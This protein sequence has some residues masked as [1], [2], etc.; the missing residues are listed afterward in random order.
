VHDDAGRVVALRTDRY[1]GRMWRRDGEG[2][3]WATVYRSPGGVS[4]R[5]TDLASADA[6]VMAVGARISPEGAVIKSVSVLLAPSVRRTEFDVTA[7]GEASLFAVTAWDG[8]WVAANTGTNGTDLWESV[9]GS[10]WTPSAT[11][12]HL[13]TLAVAA[14]DGSGGDLLAAGNSIVNG[15][16]TVVSTDSAVPRTGR[17]LQAP[18]GATPAIVVSMVANGPAPTIAYN[19]TTGTRI[20]H[21]NRG[22]L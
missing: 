3:D 7:T 10:T 11:P 21:I 4:E 5:L 6:R 9:D 20:T 22:L 14:L 15:E 16:P 12:P 2:R 18:S 19:T 17:E 1:A 8:R 13:K